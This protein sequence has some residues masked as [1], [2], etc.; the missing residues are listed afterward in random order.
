MRIRGKELTNVPMRDR[1]TRRCSVAVVVAAAA[2]AVAAGLGFQSPPKAVKVRPVSDDDVRTYVDGLVAAAAR[3]DSA[4]ING[5]IDWDAIL[6]KSTADYAAPSGFR[7]A[8]MNS[9]RQ[10]LLQKSAL[11]NDMI[12]AFKNGGDLALLRPRGKSGEKS[13]LLRLLPSKGGGVTY[14]EFFPVRRADGAIRAVDVYAMGNGEPFTKMFRRL[15]LQGVGVARGTAKAADEFSKG[16]DRLEQMRQ[17]LDANKIDEARK[18]W[19]AIPQSLQNEK[20]CMVLY[21]RMCQSLG[22]A[23]YSAA[24]AKFRKLFPNDPAADL[25]AVDA[26]VQAKEWAKALESIDRLDEAVGGDP[27]LNVLRSGVHVSAEK[28]V[29]ARDDLKKAVAGMP[30]FRPAHWSRLDLD[31]KIKDYADALE[32]M[33]GLHSKFKVVFKTDLASV[34]LFADFA[35]SPQHKE[36]LAYLKSSEKGR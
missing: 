26:F 31:L 11:A 32:V 3:G 5:M 36:W 24:L 10:S 2:L 6:E 17:A 15:Y 14:L 27:Y 34:P 18:A 30:D 9:A 12:S 20:L 19:D 28:P 33:K 23:E 25:M 4:E 7:D 22:D 13:A 16:A 8:F 1:S 21:V 29:H 35:K